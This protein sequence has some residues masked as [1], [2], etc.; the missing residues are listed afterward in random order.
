M[1]NLVKRQHFVPQTYLRKFGYSVGDEFYI[2]VLPSSC[3]SIESIFESNV[4][5]VALKK[6]LYTLSGETVEEKMAIE[7]F[8]SENLEAHYTR[9]YSLLI[10]NDIKEITEEDRELIIT[11][12]VT[13]YYRTT[14]WINKHYD[15]MNRVFIMLFDMCKQT[16]KD[17]Y[18]FEDE[19]HSIAGQTL[20]EHL[21]QYKKENQPSMVIQQLETASKLISLRL[22]SDKI[23]VYKLKSSSSELLTSDNP[24][25]AF[26]NLHK[27][28]M[29]FDPDNILSLPLDSEHILYLIPQGQKDK[30]IDRSEFTEELAF[31]E[32]QVSNSRQAGQSE[33]FMFGGKSGLETYVK[34]NAELEKVKKNGIRYYIKN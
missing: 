7:T 33:R 30:E 32:I 13:M 20:E 12:V 2:S 6:H 31:S 5:S 11:T 4:N 10:D 22:Q 27:E 24:V 23:C 8:Y 19:K 29:P 17:Y 34:F 16:E 1:S 14:W 9:I 28:F 15:V 26:N 25:L 3:D 21:S 18:M